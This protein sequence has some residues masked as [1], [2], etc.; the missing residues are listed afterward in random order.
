[1]TEI[2]VDLEGQIVELGLIGDKAGTGR[3]GYQHGVGI[4]LMLQV[5]ELCPDIHLGIM[6][7][8]IAMLLLHVAL[9]VR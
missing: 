5:K 8:H 1:M 3:Y 6:A 9:Y 2:A 4:C 7:A